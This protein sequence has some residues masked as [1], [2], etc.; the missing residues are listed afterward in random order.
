MVYL[1]KEFIGN[2]CV[3]FFQ[4]D[5]LSPAAAKGYIPGMI[6]A[7][8]LASKGAPSIADNMNYFLNC[9]AFDLFSTGALSIYQLNL[10]IYCQCQNKNCWWHYVCEFSYDANLIFCSLVCP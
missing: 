7:A 9:C 5:L 6:E 1:D 8:Q 4:N 2:A 3:K 10:C